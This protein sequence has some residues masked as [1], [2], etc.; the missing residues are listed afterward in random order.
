MV[1]AA[2]TQNVEGEKVGALNK[3]FGYAY[4]FRLLGKRVKAWNRT[5]YYVLKWTLLSAPSPMRCSSACDGYDCHSF[6]YF[7]SCAAARLN[8]GRSAQRP[9]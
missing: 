3:L 5:T 2:A 4:Q 1:R 8:A 9:R 7:S 6:I